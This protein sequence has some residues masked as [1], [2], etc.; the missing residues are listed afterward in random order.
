MSSVNS[1]MRRNLSI[2]FIILVNS[3]LIV[4]LLMDLCL[5]FLV[6]CLNYFHICKR[7]SSWEEICL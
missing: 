3:Y 4:E 1:N 7:F 6:L 5:E 2:C